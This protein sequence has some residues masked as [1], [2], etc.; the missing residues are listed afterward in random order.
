MM[1]TLS[2]AVVLLLSCTIRG[3]GFITSSASKD[4]RSLEEVSH[5]LM[6]LSVHL[7]HDDFT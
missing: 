1:I 7:V 2:L 4:L 6:V 5:T 3:V